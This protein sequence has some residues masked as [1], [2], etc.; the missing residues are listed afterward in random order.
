MNI[1][2]INSKR[3]INPETGT[4]SITAEICLWDN[5]GVYRCIVGGIPL[6]TAIEDYVTAN[7]DRLMQ[8]AEPINSPIQIDKTTEAEINM[9]LHPVAP[10]GEQIG[11]LRAQI[12]KI[13][14]AIGLA[15]TADFDHLNTVATEKIKDGQ[16]KKG[17][18]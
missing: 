18:L 1:S 10:V 7:V 17:A 8:Y 4:Q 6:G 11:I 14:N 15:P 9:I 5:N 12:A 2:V 3:V 16:T 13:L